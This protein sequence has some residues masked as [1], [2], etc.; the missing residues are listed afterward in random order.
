[1]TT[2]PSE[3]Q[4]SQPDVGRRLPHRIYVAVAGVVILFSG[5]TVM[6]LVSLS[7]LFFI[8][9]PLGIPAVLFVVLH[10]QRRSVFCRLSESDVKQTDAFEGRAEPSGQGDARLFRCADNQ[11]MAVVVDGKLQEG[12][13]YLVD[14]FED[15]LAM[16]IPQCGGDRLTARNKPLAGSMKH[17]FIT[18]GWLVAAYEA[19]FWWWEVSEALWMA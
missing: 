13:M 8:I 4:L 1:M 18:Y 19:K 7:T 14:S 10:V 15:D 17:A 3:Q 2:V 6:L 11:R 5:A 9:Y 12:V 16:L